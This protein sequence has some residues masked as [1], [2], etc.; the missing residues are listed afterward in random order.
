MGDP[1]LV[2]LHISLMLF[3]V[4]LVMFLLPVNPIICMPASAIVAIFV[5]L[6]TAFTIL[7]IV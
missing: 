1:I 3:F 6:Y 4:G 7:P 2:L 5:V